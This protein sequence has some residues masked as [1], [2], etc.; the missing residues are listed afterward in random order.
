MATFSPCP[1]SATLR[2]R[3]AS[4]TADLTSTRARPRNRWRLLRLF[5]FGLD[6]RSTMFMFIGL[7][8]Q[9]ARPCLT[10][11]VH[12]HVPFDQ[13][14]HLPLGITALDH[15]LD[16]VGVLLFGFRVP[17]AAKA[18]NRQEILDLREHAPF[19]DFTQFLVRG[20]GRVAPTV[21]RPRAQRELDDLVAEVL[22]VGDPGRL[23]DLREFLVQ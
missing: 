13:S 2:L 20:P 5:P 19:D 17:L 8:L 14:A 21:R 16:K 18:D 9:P 15:A 12:T 4:C 10:G 23:L 6:R 7:V 1:T 11:L 3:R 22:R